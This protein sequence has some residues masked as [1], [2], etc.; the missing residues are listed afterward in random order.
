MRDWLCVSAAAC[1]CL[2]TDGIRE[3]A[4]VPVERSRTPVSP[5]PPIAYK[6]PVH[7]LRVLVLSDR[8]RLFPSDDGMPSRRNRCYCTTT[9]PSTNDTSDAPSNA[10]TPKPVLEIFMGGS[11]S[12][13]S[14]MHIVQ[15]RRHKRSCTR[16]GKVGNMPPACTPAP[17]IQSTLLAFHTRQGPRTT[18]QPG[19]GRSTPAS[20]VRD[21]T[22]PCRPLH[23]RALHSTRHVRT[24]RQRGPRRRILGIVQ[25]VCC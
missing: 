7:A 15:V 17:R 12:H 13:L 19:A 16:L 1:S 24:P 21:R 3:R 2:Q 18:N 25:H 5:R 23:I 10:P 6:R 22:R 4:Q 11:I 8:S 9:A 20:L 14:C